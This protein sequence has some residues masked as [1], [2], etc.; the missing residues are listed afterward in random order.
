MRPSFNFLEWTARQKYAF[1]QEPEPSDLGG[2]G[3]AT[4]VTEAER[5]YV[6]ESFREALKLAN[7]RLADEKEKREAEYGT[8]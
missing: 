6:V 4:A 8:F 5:L 1:E 3:W 7:K 2:D